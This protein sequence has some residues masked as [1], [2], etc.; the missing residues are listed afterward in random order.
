[1][2]FGAPEAPS[3]QGS[4]MRTDVTF[5]VTSFPAMSNGSLSTDGRGPPGGRPSLFARREA[6]EQEFLWKGVF[7]EPGPGALQALP[8]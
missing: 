4:A 5:T 8:P 1:M 7:R 3:E 6:Y 2:L